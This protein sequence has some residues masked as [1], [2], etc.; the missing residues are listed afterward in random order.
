M[1]KDRFLAGGRGPEGKNIPNLTPTRLKKSSDAELKDFLVSGTTPDGD[2]PA[3]A[4]A[5]V[6]RN[7]TGQLVPGD[8]DALIAYLRSVPALP[9][10]KKD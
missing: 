2:A 9:E 4:M 6:I 10:E 3:E 5:E 7:T 8:V 1:K